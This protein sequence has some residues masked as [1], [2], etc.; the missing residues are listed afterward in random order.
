MMIL[1]ACNGISHPKIVFRF[2]SLDEGIPAS[3]NDR[4]RAGDEFPQ[5]FTFFFSQARNSFRTYFVPTI[6]VQSPYEVLH[7]REMS[8]EW[9]GNTG[10]FIKDKSF[11]LA[12]NSYVTNGEWYWL[13]GIRDFHRINFGKLFRGKEVGDKFM[14][15]ITLV[16]SF[17][18]GPENTQILEYKVTAI[19]GEYMF[20]PLV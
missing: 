1:F 17:D 4:L 16:Y 11:Q 3:A 15:T 12:V 13:G 8:Y 5:T 19:R 2:N 20:Q 14:F 9:E 7:V 6:F 10:T 18:G